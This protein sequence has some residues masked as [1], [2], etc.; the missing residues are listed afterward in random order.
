MMLI[1]DNEY[2]VDTSGSIVASESR[3]D[4][5]PLTLDEA[6]SGEV[7]TDAQRWTRSRTHLL[8][9]LM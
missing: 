5:P 6:E 9:D 1:H 3:R 8:L 2:D 4:L 7:A